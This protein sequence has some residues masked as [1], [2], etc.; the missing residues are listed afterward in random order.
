MPYPAAPGMTG[1]AWA[2][3]AE[4]AM[5]ATSKEVFMKRWWRA[6]RRANLTN[7]M[8]VDPSDIGKSD[9]GISDGL[10]RSRRGRALETVFVDGDHGEVPD[11]GAERVE[12]DGRGGWI[13][14]EHAV[15]QVVGF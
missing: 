5:A 3:P 2:A 4:Q 12:L 6:R 14:D 11:A 15:I 10:H 8:C 7:C 13:R 9:V 1:S